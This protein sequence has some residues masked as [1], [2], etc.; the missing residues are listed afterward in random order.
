MTNAQP[1][2]LAGMNKESAMKAGQPSPES[3]IFTSSDAMEEMG[4]ERSSRNET[5]SPG[6]Q[7]T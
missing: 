5:R 2:T 1:L 6:E 3:P 4:E 7:W